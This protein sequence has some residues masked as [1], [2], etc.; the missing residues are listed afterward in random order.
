MLKNNHS[1]YS[2]IN[3]FS[4]FYESALFYS[5]FGSTINVKGIRI[6]TTAQTERAN[7]GWIC[8]FMQMFTITGPRADPNCPKASI[9]PVHRD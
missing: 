2:F 8:M 5:F 9:I 1:V 6:N 3:N 4:D 7:I